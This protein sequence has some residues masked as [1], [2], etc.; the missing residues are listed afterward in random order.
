MNTVNVKNR[1]CRHRRVREMMMQSITPLLLASAVACTDATA[2]GKAQN[3]AGGTALG[4]IPAVN[5]A[6]NALS[7]GSYQDGLMMGHRNGELIVGRLRAST[8]GVKGCMA[9][10][11]LEQA[12]IKVAQNISAPVQGGDLL[13]RGFFKGYLDSVRDGIYQTRK[14]CQVASYD[15]GE[16]AGVFYGTMLCKVSQIS[17]DIAQ[18]LEVEALYEGWS[19]SSS[20]VKQECRIA[21]SVTLKSCNLSSNIEMFDSDQTLDLSQILNVAVQTSCSD[22]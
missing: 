2:M 21:A 7:A 16:W 19:G 1:W 18:S 3:S 10:P 5:G 8:V 22:S 6:G 13:V 20:I 12:L 9:L 15:N 14:G 4:G 11:K 17:I